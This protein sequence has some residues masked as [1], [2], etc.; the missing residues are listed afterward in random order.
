MHLFFDESGDFSFPDDRYDVYTQAVLIAP[1]SKLDEFEEWV[2]SKKAEWDVDEL[3]AVKL[4]DGQVW[5]ICR[6][7]R[8]QRLP[9]L[10]QATDTLAITRETIA[11]H[12]LN[13]AVRIHQN[14]EAWKAAGGT[15]ESIE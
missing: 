10:V 6:F 7:V 3:H 9:L 11:E 8:A 14:A 5:G 13:Q 2:H 1:D 4:T 15:A 12:R